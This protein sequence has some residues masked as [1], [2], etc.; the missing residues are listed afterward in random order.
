MHVSVRTLHGLRALSTLAEEPGLAQSA[1]ELSDQRYID[2]DYLTQ[3][4]ISLKQ[5]EI[6]GSKKGPSGGYYLKRSPDS[7]TLGEIFR[8]LEG[9]TVISPC[10]KPEHSDCD[11]ISAC[12]T[13]DTLAFVADR[14][15]DFL[16]QITLSD[17][18]ASTQDPESLSLGV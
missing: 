11:I 7:I 13:Q 1:Q 17:L 5:D 3:I 2:R 9:P 15:D 6:V 18:Q 12:N 14:I 4:M 16:D 8:S 10:T